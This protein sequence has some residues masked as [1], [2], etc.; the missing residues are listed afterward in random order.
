M[1]EGSTKKYFVPVTHNSWRGGR[2]EQI[3]NKEQ[4]EV[5]HKRRL[6]V[7]E[8]KET[9]FRVLLQECLPIFQQ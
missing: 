9:K 8:R 3:N 6:M 2:C 4:L 7:Q 5:H 1:G